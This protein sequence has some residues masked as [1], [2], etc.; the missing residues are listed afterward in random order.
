M[1][2][3]ILVIG[4]KSVG[5]TSFINKFINNSFDERYNYTIGIDINNIK[6]LDKDIQ[7]IDT[8]GQHKYKSDITKYYCDVNV[9]IILFDVSNIET[10]IN[11]KNYIFEI[12][13]YKKDDTT[14]ILVG[15][16]MDLNVKIS[17]KLLEEYSYEYNIKIFLIS[18]KNDCVNNIFN[19]ILDEICNI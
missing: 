11:V 17:K 10:F 19:Y 12:E 18:S 4:D 2:I 16:K 8:S 7:I 13:K 14:Y 9:V 5:K 3:K 6:Y 15:N 1:V